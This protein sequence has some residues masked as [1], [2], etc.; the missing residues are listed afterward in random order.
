MAQRPIERS[1]LLE[2]AT[3]ITALRGM[4]LSIVS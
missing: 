3:V 1:V 4:L 2:G